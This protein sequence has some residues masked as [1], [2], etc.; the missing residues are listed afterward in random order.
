MAGGTM[1]KLILAGALLG[2]VACQPGD[3]SQET[4]ST[5][6]GLI[7]D[8]NAQSS[9]D[10]KNEDSK[11]SYAIGLRYGEAIGRDLKELDLE[12]FTL[13]MEH[14]FKGKPALLKSEE[15][16]ATLQALQARK[17]AEM[18]KVAAEKSSVNKEVGDKFLADNA[19]RDGVKTTAS[20]LQY[21]VITAGS[22]ESPKPTDEVT[23]HYHGTLVN[24]EVFDSSVQRGQPASFPV[25]GVIPGWTEA[26]QLMKKGDKWKLFI[27]ST[28]AYGERGAGG[29]IGPNETLIFEVELLGIN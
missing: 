19:K 4:A 24:G 26:L 18:E 5:S 1:K 11:A 15:V 13:G 27:P 9:S 14:G 2:L 17:M 12:A 25:N 3:N 7:A 29:K 8:A 23:V 16:M 6:N 21:E 10:F 20:G 28:L 22:G